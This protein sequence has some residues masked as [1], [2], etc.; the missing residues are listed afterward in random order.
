MRE[1]RH[2]ERRNH[3]I[4][5]KIKEHYLKIEAD[6]ALTPEETAKELGV[7]IDIVKRLERESNEQVIS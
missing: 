4:R 6:Y 5:R 3:E 1:R 2:G 7:T